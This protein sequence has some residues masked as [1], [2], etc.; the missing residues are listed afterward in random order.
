M[1]RS[2]PA[3]A[4]FCSPCSQA[5]EPNSKPRVAGRGF[6]E[7]QEPDDA[8]PGPDSPPDR[9]LDARDRVRAEP[10]PV[11]V[12]APRRVHEPQHPL[13]DQVVEREA[14]PP[15]PPRDLED[16]AKVGLDELVGGPAVACGDPLAQRP[17][18]LAGQT[19]DSP[20]RA[21]EPRGQFIVAPPT[22]GPA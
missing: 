22:A 3:S 11:G 14:R 18:L 7:G 5:A 2:F 1:A 16:E 19:G 17:L 21:G 6:G 13:L 12:E 8:S 15:E 10:C 20:R 4:S 9:A